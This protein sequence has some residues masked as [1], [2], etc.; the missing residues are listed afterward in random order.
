MGRFLS[1]RLSLPLIV[2][3]TILEA[4]FDSQ[5]CS[6]RA[7]RSLLS[8]ASDEVLF[9]LAAASQAAILVNWWDHGSS[10]ARLQRIS[11]RIVEVFCDCP[12]DLAAARFESRVRPRGHHDESRSPEENGEGLRRA[13]DT[14]PGPLRI[15]RLVRV[16][17]EGAVDADTVTGQVRSA[18]TGAWT[19]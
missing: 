5:G 3:D 19:G 10:P 9:S 6:D 16:D 17:T 8:R 12:V 15:G 13:R 4:M 1:D 7:E 11:S 2:K 18:L 14:F